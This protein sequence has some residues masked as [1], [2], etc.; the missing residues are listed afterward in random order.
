MHSMSMDSSGARVDAE[1]YYRIDTRFVRHPA[2]VQTLCQEAR[3]LMPSM[4]MDSLGA[5][6]VT[7][8]G[9]PWS[10]RGPAAPTS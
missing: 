9:L 7:E 4:S 1:S 10:P 2:I 5:R 8:N 6:A 3:G